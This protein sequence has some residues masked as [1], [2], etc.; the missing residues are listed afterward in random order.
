MVVVALAASSSGADAAGLTLRDTGLTGS[1]FRTD[2][3]RYIAVATSVS[4]VTV[5]DVRDGTRVVLS[6]PQDCSLADV[7]HGAVLWTCKTP[8]SGIGFFDTGIVQDI[9][10]GAR[11]LLARTPIRAGDSRAEGGIYAELGDRFVRSTYSGYHDDGSLYTNLATREVRQIVD[12]RDRVVQLDG[13]QLTRRL[14]RGQRRP[15]VGD[16]VGSELIP[17]P[18]AIAGRWAADT[19]YAVGDAFARVQLQRCGHRT[20][21]LHRCRATV[22]YAPVVDDRVVAW[23]ERPQSRRFPVSLAVRS[24]RSGRVRRVT[25]DSYGLSPLLVDGRLYVVRTTPLGSQPLAPVELRLMHA[26]L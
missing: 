8:P 23:E 16:S 12:R 6:T 14:C 10:T 22:C 24:H 1:M 2:G 21:T 7:H 15:L 13:P 18:L 5:I 11:R 26:L 17:G 20:R 4:D 25:E 9:A 3:E 19:T